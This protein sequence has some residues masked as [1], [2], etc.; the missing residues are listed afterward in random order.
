M[1]HIVLKHSFSDISDELIRSID[2][3]CKEKLVKYAVW[4]YP[5][6]A[7]GLQ[8]VQAE[9]EDNMS[10]KTYLDGFVAVHEDTIKRI[11]IE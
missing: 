5:I 1:A 2:K 4:S 7:K 9:K 6:Y 8:S 11:R 10:L 3:P